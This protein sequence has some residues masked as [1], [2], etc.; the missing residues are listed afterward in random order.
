MKADKIFAHPEYEF[1]VFMDGMIKADWDDAICQ[2]CGGN[3]LKPVYCCSG[4]ECC[5]YGLPCEFTE[6]DCGSDVP[7]YETIK[8]W[9]D[10][11][12]YE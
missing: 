1:C 4:N 3:G 12:R 10:E 5:C 2:D 8:R 9:S 6:C 7:K 11:R